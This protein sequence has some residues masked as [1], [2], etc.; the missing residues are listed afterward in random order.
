MIGKMVENVEYIRIAYIDV[1]G[2]TL[3]TVFLLWFEVK[4]FQMYNYYLCL[5]FAISIKNCKWIEIREVT[6]DL[7]HKSSITR[8]FAYFKKRQQKDRLDLMAKAV[9]S[10]NNKSAIAEAIKKNVKVDKKKAR[11]SLS[12]RLQTKSQQR[13]VESFLPTVIL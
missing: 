10:K 8:F 7:E 12:Q 5:F 11:M 6:K 1:E 2:S 3:K 9:T 13:F 4:P